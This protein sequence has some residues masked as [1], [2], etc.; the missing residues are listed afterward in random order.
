MSGTSNYYCYYYYYN[1]PEG[2]RLQFFRFFGG[3]VWSEGRKKKLKREK[4]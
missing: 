2:I 3:W 1:K 4:G